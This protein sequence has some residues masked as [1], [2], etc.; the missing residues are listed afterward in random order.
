[1]L[2][3]DQVAPHPPDPLKLSAVVGRAF[4]G[5]LGIPILC[6]GREGG[7]VVSSKGLG[8]FNGHSQ[9]CRYKLKHFAIELYFDMINYFFN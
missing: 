4:V 8:T 6:M 9:E 5:L 1:M 2:K 7:R 3:E